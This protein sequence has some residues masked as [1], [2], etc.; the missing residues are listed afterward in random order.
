[1]SFDKVADQRQRFGSGG[2]V[3]AERLHGALPRSC[4]VDDIGYFE[5]V[6]HVYGRCGE[7]PPRR[8]ADDVGVEFADAAQNHQRRRAFTHHLVGDE[9]AVQ[10]FGLLFEQAVEV[11]HAPFAEDAGHI[12]VADYARARFDMQQVDELQPLVVGQKGRV[13]F[14]G[15]SF[16]YPNRS[17]AR[18]IAS[19]ISTPNGH[20]GS[21]SPQPMHSEAWC[22]SVR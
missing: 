5:R 21:H 13:S 19:T 7:Q 22:A 10:Q 14:H 12:A 9:G 1:M 18:R 11:F 3:A 17:A 6:A 15:L 4:P 16:Q 2:A 20:R 8:P